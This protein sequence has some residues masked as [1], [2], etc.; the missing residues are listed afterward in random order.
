MV[1]RATVTSEPTPEPQPQADAVPQGTV[2]TGIGPRGKGTRTTI[3]GPAPAQPA[4]AADRPAW[5]P[6][7]FKS[8]EELAASYAQLEQRLGGGGQPA[9]A[10]D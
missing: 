4:P 2:Q 7:K 1:D 3:D 8:P 5:L 6:S 10:T 9:P